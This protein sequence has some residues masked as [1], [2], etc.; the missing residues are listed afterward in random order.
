MN[1]YLSIPLHKAQIA[2]LQKLVEGGELYIREDYDDAAVLDPV[3]IDCEIV[4][5]NVPAI[6]IENAPKL[7]WIQLESVGFGE[8]RH[9]DWSRLDQQVT[10]TNLAGFFADPVAQS[11][12]AGILA[13]YRGIEQLVLL[14]QNNKWIGDPLREGLRSLTGARVV[15]LGYGS[16]NR[17]LAELLSPYQ[18][19]ITYFS[20]DW[21]T[22]KL[23]QALAEADIVVSAVPE[24]DATLQLFNHA[25]L[26]LLKQDALF[27]NVGRGS[28]V[29]EH[30]LAQ[31]LQNRRIASA[32]I[33]VT[34]DEPL[35]DDH[36]FWTMPN[37]L[38]TQHSGGGT[39]DELDR[40]IDL[41]AENLARY[42]AQEQLLGIVD[43]ARGY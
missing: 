8:Y 24:T 7:K 28:V 17:R 16:I 42:R 37:T 26:S 33:D 41:F 1:I 30:A 43:F 25:R 23:D 4:F 15:L 20:S 29:D 12:M 27:V 5:G 18:C 21:T 10:V 39:K 19:E 11:V 36:P 9:L 32:V 6:W 22:T 13:H 31:A 2:R 40:K 38:L 35:P 34:V 14:K 3:F